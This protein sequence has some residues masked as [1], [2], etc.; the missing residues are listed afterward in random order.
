[1]KHETWNKTR[2]KSAYGAFLRRETREETFSMRERAPLFVLNT[3]AII[4]L[5]FSLVSS[6]NDLWRWL[7]FSLFKFVQIHCFNDF[8]FFLFFFKFLY[9]GLL[10][11]FFT[12]LELPLVASKLHLMS[13][14][15]HNKQRC[16]LNITTLSITCS[17][18]H[19]FI[20]IFSTQ[21]R[22]QIELLIVQDE[23]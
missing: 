5:A 6:T 20:S 23:P 21:R 10:F 15:H 19:S 17:S 9:E 14:L 1:M 2:V 8:S 11:L 3:R 4:I 12:S 16:Q 22:E 7:I 13:S 18:S